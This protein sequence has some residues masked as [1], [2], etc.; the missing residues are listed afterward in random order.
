M[1]VKPGGRVDT[2]YID[3]ITVNTLKTQIKL[4]VFNFTRAAMPGVP[5]E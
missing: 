1:T 5:D 2:P 3:N 4:K